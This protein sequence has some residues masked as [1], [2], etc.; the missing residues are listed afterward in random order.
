MATDGVSKRWASGATGKPPQVPNVRRL[1]WSNVPALISR[2]SRSARPHLPNRGAEAA[3]L[4]HE[5]RSWSMT[6]RSVPPN[7]RQFGGSERAIVLRA[8][9]TATTTRGSCQA[10]EEDNEVRWQT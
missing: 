2:R 6:F 1:F 3:A 4:S 10:Q 8:K 7:R 5:I 9:A